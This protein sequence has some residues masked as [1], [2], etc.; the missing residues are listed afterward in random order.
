MKIELKYSRKSDENEIVYCADYNYVVNLRENG[1]RNSKIIVE[2]LEKGIC[3]DYESDNED[4]RPNQEYDS[5]S[6]FVNDKIEIKNKRNDKR[7]DLRAL[8]D[9]L[10][11]RFS[12][13]VETIELCAG[14][15]RWELQD[16]LPSNE[17]LTASAMVIH[18][19]NGKEYF[20]KNVTMFSPYRDSANVPEEYNVNEVC[21]DTCSP[22]FY[23]LQGEAVDGDATMVHSFTKEKLYRDKKVLWL[24]KG[25]FQHTEEYYIE[26][27][28]DLSNCGEPEWEEYGLGGIVTITYEDALNY[29]G[30][31]F[32][33]NDVLSAEP[34]FECDSENTQAVWKRVT[35]PFHLVP[36][37]AVYTA[38]HEC[39]FG[40]VDVSIIM[41][42]FGCDIEKAWKTE[43]CKARKIIA[44][45]KAIG[46][47]ADLQTAVQ[48]ALENS[49]FILKTYKMLTGNT[50]DETEST[51]S[52][53]E[54]MVCCPEDW[55]KNYRFEVWI[56]QKE[57]KE[58]M[59][60]RLN[61]SMKNGR[62]ELNKLY[63]IFDNK[64]YVFK[65]KGNVLIFAECCKS[66]KINSNVWP[67]RYELTTD[68]TD[69][70]LL[71][72]E[73]RKVIE[74]C[75]TLMKLRENIHKLKKIRE[76]DMRN[77]IIQEM[78]ENKIRFSRKFLEESFRNKITEGSEEYIVSEQ[79]VEEFT[80]AFADWFPVAAISQR[81]GIAV[82]KLIRDQY[83]VKC[84]ELLPIPWLALMGEAGTGK[85]TVARRL[86]ENC[87]GASFGETLGSMLKGAYLGQTKLRV[88]AIINKL[89]QK[90]GAGHPAVLFIDEAYSLF[91][92]DDDY[93]SEVIE[94]ILAI[95]S[96]KD[97]YRIDVSD[98]SEE[99]RIAAGLADQNNQALREVVV[100]RNTAIW[101]GGYEERLR[102]SFR[103]NEGLS[104]R[105]AYQ[106][107]IPTPSL[108]ELY[109][110]FC[111]LFRNRKLEPTDEHKVRELLGWGT[112]RTRS[113]L[114]GN[115][116]GVNMLLNYCDKYLNIGYDVSSAI[117]K[118]IARVK[119]NINRQYSAELK[120][121][122]GKMPFEVISDVK[123]NLDDSYAGCEELKKEINEVIDLM[124]EPKI[125]LERRI[126]L[127]KGALLVGSPGTGK[128]Y[129][130]R[131]MAG[132][133]NKR[134]K[135]KCTK[136][137]NTDAGNLMDVAFIPLSGAQI[138]A[139]NQ[140]VD[141]V[142]VLF[143]EASKYDAVIIFLD[144]V[145]T[146]GNL[147]CN[148]S[149]K[150]A[151][152]T[153]LMV[154]M[155]GF[156]ENGNIFVLA[157]TNSPEKLNPAFKREGRFDMTF[158]INK[159][160]RK[161]SFALIEMELKKY[162]L[163]L[164][165][166]FMAEKEYN[167]CITKGKK[168]SKEQ[169]ERIWMLLGGMVPAK[170]AAVLNQA[171][172]L[173]HRT[174][175][176]LHAEDYKGNALP[177]MHRQIKEGKYLTDAKY[178]SDMTVEIRNLEGFIS[179]IK[180]TLDIKAIGRRSEP[181]EEKSK[182][183]NLERNELDASSIAIHEVG[184][185][186]M[187][188]LLF[189]NFNLERITI[190]GRG[191]AAGYVE[192][193][194]DGRKLITK[195]DYENQIKICM[196]GRIAE[197]IVY[198]D[199]S[200]GASQDLIDATKYARCMVEQLGFSNE[201]GFMSLGEMGGGYLCNTYY[202]TCSEGMRRQAEEAIQAILKNCYKSAKEVL[203]ENKD[204]LIALAKEIFVQ[205]EV[206]GE[207]LEK[208]YEKLSKSKS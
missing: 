160:D 179:D 11:R 4:H 99:R 140:P 193:S 53:W 151:V 54:Y 45:K 189:G 14:A 49:S 116:S 143:S 101:L 19:K 192:H 62:F 95:A 59:E 32:Y 87:L 136:S 145:D 184:H 70:N 128:S 146:I 97:G 190:L 12:G 28:E 171:V 156:G 69:L 173:Y 7:M 6:V 111:K 35:E 110:L 65:T 67:S 63:V 21:A 24:L 5:Y 186:L 149:V 37:Y 131:C 1:E 208:L 92:N 8:A 119:E 55:E 169:S 85:T 43:D 206:S 152:M 68:Y 10:V 17:N 132:Q 89:Q 126:R 178:E 23:L 129:L 103:V 48:E 46:A 82:K 170:V 150:E 137:E 105:F 122:I 125:S 75:K 47:E 158:E 142:K 81:K 76:Y 199:I 77:Y 64:Q 93:A 207:R 167:P 42:G 174:E 84:S 154:E 83:A 201:I 176:G 159:P 123:E 72:E 180:E 138:L 161:T 79:L 98:V 104:R 195:K 191:D 66:K 13:S 153:Q 40:C 164:H 96:S 134:I 106:I 58:T 188:K 135:E 30:T 196:G 18:A 27:K 166:D 94:M 74:S 91:E 114:F 148:D 29:Q 20:F 139:N 44:H 41:R 112:S 73:D 157:A 60:Y 120:S 182:E 56:R 71:P 200:I 144:E 90:E 133:L 80:P 31:F 183:F 61:M 86:A 205:K 52:K 118:A 121:N 38:S 204:I 172:I 181:R 124:I 202:N 78:N 117:Q 203:T 155:D 108:D 177:Y 15:E 100:H 115:R 141:A 163:R 51:G 194:K 187:S 50:L 165:P 185:A 16:V 102:H 197:E 147:N 9:G 130:A 168:F 198:D 36:W 26:E 88:A 109:E 2:T 162:G 3:D 127:P 25:S 34:G 22:F 57:A 39:T 113:H 33:V 175:K 107:T